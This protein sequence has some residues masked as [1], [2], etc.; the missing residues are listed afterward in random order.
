MFD[1]DN[2]NVDDIDRKKFQELLFLSGYSFET[3]AKEFDVGVRTVKN[4]GF[5][6]AKIPKWASK[7]LMSNLDFE[8]SIT[9]LKFLNNDYN[10]CKSFYKDIVSEDGI[11]YVKKNGVDLKIRIKDYSNP[12]EYLNDDL[13]KTF[14]HKNPF[15]EN[16]VCSDVELQAFT[17]HLEHN[18]NVI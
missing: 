17:Q 13:K 5:G 3:F 18:P 1:S 2:F 16:Q 9:F 15:L 8:K 11:A 7:F 14:F 12:R 6:K 4:W 10:L